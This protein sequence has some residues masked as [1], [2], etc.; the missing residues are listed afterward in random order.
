MNENHRTRRHGVTARL[1]VA[2][3]AAAALGLSLS[4]CAMLTEEYS[5]RWNVDYEVTSDGGDLSEVQSL[6]YQHWGSTID[7]DASVTLPSDDGE[8]SALAAGSWK[9]STIV[10]AGRE[11]RVTVKGGTTPLSCR[12]VLDGDRVVAEA[13]AAPG[14]TLECAATLPKFSE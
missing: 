8:R 2:G 14:E 6:T 5:D 12:I 4:G 9:E 3:L 7:R 11:A 1:G 10:G 13:T